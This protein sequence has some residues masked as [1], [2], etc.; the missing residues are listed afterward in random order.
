MPDAI[1]ESVEAVRRPAQHGERDVGPT[2]LVK[3][4]RM[5][6]LSMGVGAVSMGVGAV[7]T[8]HRSFVV[9]MVAVLL[10][11]VGCPARAAAA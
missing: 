11:L 3:P 5:S 1:R 7:Q 10:V 6:G 9:A 4:V 2:R 8:A